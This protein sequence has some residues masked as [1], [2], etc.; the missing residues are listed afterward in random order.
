MKSK[1]IALMVRGASLKEVQDKKFNIYVGISLGNKWFTKSHLKENLLWCLQYTKNRAGLLIGDTLHSINYEVRNGDSSE[2]A[3]R[4][5]LKK[6]DEMVIVLEQIIKE[7]PLEEQR[8]IDIIRWDE[9]KK[10]S[11]NKEF[12]SIFYKEYEENVIFRMEI[13]KIVNLHLADNNFTEEQKIKL[14]TYI[15][16]E[17]PELLH[18]FDYYGTF[19]DCYTYPYDGLLNQMVEKIQNKELFPEFHKKLDIKKHVFVELRS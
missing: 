1:A 14:G 8:R 4:K 16:E 7:L 19:Y 9:V 11:F 15:L 6:G 3:R 18:G 5:A 10:S 17:L 13:L 2:K 12:L